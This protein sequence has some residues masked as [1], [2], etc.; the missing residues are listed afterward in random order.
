MVEVA[1][2]VWPEWLKHLVQL[3]IKSGLSELQQQ[4]KSQR[5]FCWKQHI[6]LERG[7]E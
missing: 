4:R 5:G 6:Y 1:R 2:A 3:R 7:K